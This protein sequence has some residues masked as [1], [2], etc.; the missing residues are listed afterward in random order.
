MSGYYEVQAY[1]I[2][3]NKKDEV[4]AIST[5]D[6][7][8]AY[9]GYPDEVLHDAWVRKYDRPMRE[10]IFRGEV[11]PKKVNHRRVGDLNYFP[12]ENWTRLDN[13]EVRE[14]V[15][16]R[17]IEVHDVDDHP[18][19]ESYIPWEKVDWSRFRRDGHNII[20]PIKKEELKE[21]V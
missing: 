15:M 12:L 21:A 18:P 5:H 3:R 20:S 11:N 17:G 8:H 10:K 2:I 7:G 6:S 16:N 19:I 1:Y 14:W 4:W 13:P 9:I